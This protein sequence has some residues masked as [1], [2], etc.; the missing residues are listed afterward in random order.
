MASAHLESP[1]DVSALPSIE[2]QL[3]STLVETAE[4]IRYV[5]CFDDEQRAEVYAILEALRG[6]TEAHRA[7]VDLLARQVKTG[8]GRG[9]A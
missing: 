3:A 2:H 5:E 8:G 9:H 6:D 4:E 1:S 7:M